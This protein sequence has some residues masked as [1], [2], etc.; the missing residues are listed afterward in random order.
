MNI[1][2]PLP[3]F[4]APEFVL[5]QEQRKADLKELEATMQDVQ[6]ARLSKGNPLSYH[7]NV[8]HRLV[9]DLVI[10]DSQGKE[11][12]IRASWN[13]KAFNNA[14]GNVMISSINANGSENVSTTIP[15]SELP[16]PIKQALK[17]QLAAKN[18]THSHPQAAKDAQKE[19]DR[20]HEYL[21]QA[22]KEISV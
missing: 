11:T 2:A 4:K 10:T 20:Y 3:T 13:F 8:Q 21:F 18:A 12:P 5:K 19:V 16:A 22:K 7:T 17:P 9:S 1:T 6:A 14:S 15:A